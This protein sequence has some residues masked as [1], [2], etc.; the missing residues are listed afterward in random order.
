MVRRG[1]IGLVLA[2]IPTLGINAAFHSL[3]G[4]KDSFTQRVENA[5]A[6]LSLFSLK[7]ECRVA[8]PL[9]N[10]GRPEADK[11]TMDT[12]VLGW[13]SQQTELLDEIASEMLQLYAKGG[14]DRRIH[15]T[16]GKVLFEEASDSLTIHVPVSTLGY[17]R[18]VRLGLQF[19]RDAEVVFTFIDMGGHFHPFHKVISTQGDTAAVNEQ[20]DVLATTGVAQP[21]HHI[22]AKTMGETAGKAGPATERETSAQEAQKAAA[23]ET[24]D[25]VGAEIGDKDIPGEQLEVETS[26]EDAQ[27][28]MTGEVGAAAGAKGKPGSTKDNE[29]ES[30]T[31]LQ[32]LWQKVGEPQYR[33][34]KRTAIANIVWDVGISA[35][36]LVIAFVTAKLMGSING[37]TVADMLRER[38]VR[39]LA[40]LRASEID[41]TVLSSETHVHETSFERNPPTEEDAAVAEGVEANGMLKSPS[42]TRD[43][44]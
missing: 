36:F 13:T 29:E 31:Y 12:I 34:L 17:A 35:A 44:V 2:L 1:V 14:K 15:K 7:R 5:A 6:E 42:M 26:V 20:R 40:S 38:R 43:Q 23:Q 22:T 10:L 18:R 39:R 28:K 24:S 33:E 25:Q 32:L 4:S 19:E 11:L 27:M 21:S 37:R 30:I 16:E 3:I 9:G 41:I 8:L